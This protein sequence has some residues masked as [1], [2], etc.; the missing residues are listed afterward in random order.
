MFDLDQSLSQGGRRSACEVV[1]V[2]ITDDE[3]VYEEE[4]DI[5]S[6]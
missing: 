4:E 2:D 6:S 1:E 5:V 3:M